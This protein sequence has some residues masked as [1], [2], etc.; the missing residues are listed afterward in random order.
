MILKLGFEMV[1]VQCTKVL[2]DGIPSDKF[3]YF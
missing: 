3:F 1:T 2:G